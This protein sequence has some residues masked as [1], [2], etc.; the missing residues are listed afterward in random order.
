M[1]S[2]WASIVGVVGTG[3][4]ALIAAFAMG[5]IVPSS[6]VADARREGDAKV[7]EVRAQ[8]EADAREAAAKLAEAQAREE[9][10]RKEADTWH[11]SHDSIKDAFDGQ[12]KILE[13]QQL[14][15]EITDRLMS[16]VDE[17]LASRSG[18]GTP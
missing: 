2:I 15:A 13:R 9:K 17:R 3:V 10:A 11:A 1:D 14:T 18:G 8:A 5:K 6:K 7:A 4:V 16:V 12:T